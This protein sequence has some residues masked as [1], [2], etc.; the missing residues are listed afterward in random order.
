MAGFP[1]GQAGGEGFGLRDRLACRP[2]VPAVQQHMPGSATMARSN[3]SIAP[4]CMVSFASQPR[5][6]ASRAADEAVDK[7]RS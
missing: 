7:G 5:T 3:V 2:R 1:G 4:G 6:Y